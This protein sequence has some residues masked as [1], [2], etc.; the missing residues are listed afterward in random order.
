MTKLAYAH[1]HNTDVVLQLRKSKICH[2]GIPLELTSAEYNLIMFN[3][4]SHN[5]HISAR[6]VKR[7]GFFVS[8]ISCITY[9]WN[10]IIRFSW[11]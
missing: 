3:S 5:I 6:R 9:N 8:N 1:K 4:G 7:G 10:C 11:C 2:S